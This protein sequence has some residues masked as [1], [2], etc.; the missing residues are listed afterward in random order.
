MVYFHFSDSHQF[1]LLRKNNNLEL[2]FG[3]YLYFQLLCI[4][5]HAILRD[6]DVLDAKI[7]YV[8]M[9]HFIK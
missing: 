3:N 2:S 8:I 9:L 5:K 7:W 6:R 4:I 1:N